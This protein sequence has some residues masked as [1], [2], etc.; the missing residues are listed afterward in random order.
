MSARPVEVILCCPE[1]C[2]FASTSPELCLAHDVRM[3]EGDGALLLRRLHSITAPDRLTLARAIAP[4]GWVVVQRIAT[5]EQILAGIGALN[6]GRAYRNEPPLH[7]QHNVA[8]VAAIFDAM[9]AA[10]R[11]ETT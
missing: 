11:K 3:N 9:I 6:E 1:G 10:A 5:K 7:A 4:D 8:D 2:R